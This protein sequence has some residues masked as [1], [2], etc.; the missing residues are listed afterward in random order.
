[1]TDPTI[2]SRPMAQDAGDRTQKKPLNPQIHVVGLG[3]AGAASLSADVM[4]I[5]QA[6]SLLMGSDRHLAAFPQHPAR[7]WVLGDLGEALAQLEIFLQG[8]D[9]GSQACGAI[10]AQSAAQSA[11]HSAV[12]L[13]SGDPLFFGLGRLLLAQLPPE[14]LTFHPHLSA[15]QLAFS[16]LKRPW[17]DA[18]L[19]SVHGRSFEQ[20]IPLVQQGGRDIAILTD[21]HHSPAAIAQL[22]LSLELPLRYRCWVCENL[23]GAAERVQAYSL[24]ELAALS[25]ASL[26]ILV[27]IA[28]PLL[29]LPEPLP[30][31]GIA[32]CHFATFPDR[33]GLMTKQPVRSLILAELSLQPGQIIWDIGA[34]TG[35]VSI[36]I[37]RLCPS[38]HIYAIE[39][40]A[41]GIG[42]IGQNR[43]RFS[44]PNVVPISGSA[45]EALVNLPA[46]DRIFIGGSGS[47]LPGVLEQ[48]SE[49]LKPDGVIVLAIATLETLADAQRWFRQRNWQVDLMQVQLSR[50]AAIAH[51]TRW[52]PLN[53][54]TL[55]SARRSDRM[56]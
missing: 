25:C 13:T 24:E 11:A 4:A 38:S 52:S 9:P 12:V 47:A 35:S 31:V 55:V 45:P 36:E 27:L 56:S 22:I 14:R 33:P 48:C 43:D 46:P 32:D 5:V 21:P 37:A 10:A 1:M 19:V 8:D 28:E 50:G 51:L 20:L 40:T 16:R 54:V 49:Q 3:L 42:L 18:A 34:G 41:A 26:S 17:Q 39:K 2:A 7:R 53:P 15:I 44:T 23:G 30:L 6:T 29:P